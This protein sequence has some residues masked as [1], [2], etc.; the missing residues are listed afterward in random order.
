M[1]L[2][3]PP[4]LYKPTAG[5]VSGVLAASSPRPRCLALTDPRGPAA[6]TLLLALGPSH[7]SAAP[8]APAPRTPASRARLTASSFRAAAA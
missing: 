4:D 5:K 8:A 7:I 3:S 2:G 6:P 1:S